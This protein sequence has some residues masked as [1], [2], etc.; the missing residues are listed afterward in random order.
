MEESLSKLPLKPDRALIDGYPLKN[1]NIPNEGIIGGDDIIDSIKAASII[2][3]VFR[4]KIM[5]DYSKIFPEYEF[6]SNSGYGTR[7]HMD[8]LNNFKATPIHRKTFKPVS[9]NMPSISWYKKNKLLNWIGLKIVALHMYKIGYS[10]IK[11]NS[12]KINEI[13]LNL[14]VKR[15][16]KFIIIFVQVFCNVDKT[17]LKENFDKNK[18]IKFQLN[19]KS[20]I[21]NNPQINECESKIAGVILSKYGPKTYLYDFSDFI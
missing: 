5:L 19:L 16:K 3:K 18:I 17:I 9:I 7:S 20:Y 2:A 6:Q 4:D 10:I 11:I 13:H 12:Y 1:Q 21:N 15:K 8:A 14:I